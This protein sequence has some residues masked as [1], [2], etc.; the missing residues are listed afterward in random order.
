MF[1]SIGYATFGGTL[2]SGKRLFVCIIGEN[3]KR[4]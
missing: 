4:P 3:I 1:Q 2:F